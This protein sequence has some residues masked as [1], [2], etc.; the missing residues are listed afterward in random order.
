MPNVLN[1]WFRKRFLTAV[2]IQI[3]AACAMI[4]LNIPVVIAV[5]L[6]LSTL[7]GNIAGALG[8]LGI[9]LTQAKDNSES[10]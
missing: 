8:M 9:V 10:K 4:L 1:E 2:L 6:C 5:L 3:A 7:L